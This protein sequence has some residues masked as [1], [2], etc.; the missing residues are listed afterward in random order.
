M[1]KKFFGDEW[2]KLPKDELL[3]ARARLSGFIEA[4]TDKEKLIRDVSITNSKYKSKISHA[5]KKA[6]RV[7]TAALKLGEVNHLELRYEFLPPRCW[8]RFCRQESWARLPPKML[9]EVFYRQESWAKLPLRCWV[10]FAAKN[11]EVTTK[12]LVKDCRQQ[13]KRGAAKA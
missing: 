8:A 9:G 12:G 7:Y 2:E 6:G 10:R 3:R 5:A 11:G 4:T 1:A 13:A